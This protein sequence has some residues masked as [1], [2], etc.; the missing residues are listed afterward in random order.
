MDGAG[1]KRTHHTDNDSALSWNPF[2]AVNRIFPNLKELNVKLG[3]GLVGSLT[4]KEKGI[5]NSLPCC[6]C[7]CQGPCVIGERLETYF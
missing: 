7:L 2:R 1:L 5:N 3:G 4:D 6:G